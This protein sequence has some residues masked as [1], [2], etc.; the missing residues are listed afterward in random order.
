[1]SNPVPPFL[2]A[3]I[4]DFQVKPEVREGKP[5]EDLKNFIPESAV[6]P[7]PEIPQQPFDYGREVYGGSQAREN[8]QEGF[9]QGREEEEEE[10]NQLNPRGDVFSKQ[11]FGFG[12]WKVIV[13]F[14][15]A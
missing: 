4:P 12:S 9:P 3:A 10:H 13:F 1:M 5:D 11:H 8:Q 6:T 14:L 7:P 15:T 2:L